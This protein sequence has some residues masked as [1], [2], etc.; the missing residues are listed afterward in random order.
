MQSTPHLFRASF[1]GLGL[2][3]RRISPVNASTFTKAQHVSQRVAVS[4]PL[5][6]PRRCTSQARP[7]FLKPSRPSS[8]VPPPFRASRTSRQVR[9][10]STSGSPKPNPNPTPH[11]GSPEPAPSLSARLRKLTREYG[12]TALGLYLALSALDFPFCFLAVRA[13]GTDRIGRW[14]HAIIDGVQN[15]LA[16]VGLDLRRQGQTAEGDVEAAAASV[17]EGYSD[18]GFAEADA[19]NKGA[20]A[21][22]WNLLRRILCHRLANEINSYL[23]AVS[24]GLCYP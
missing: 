5:I 24:S 11:L 12:W 10:N 15:L 13:L 23:D 18:H 9:F 21:S 22:M 8:L 4:Q 17:R 19:A 14:E 20:D 2:R 6:S 3:S 1:S 7:R 16:N